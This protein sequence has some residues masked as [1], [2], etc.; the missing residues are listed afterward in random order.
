M[1][2][3]NPDIL[4]AIPFIL[5]FVAVLCWFD[6]KQKKPLYG[7][8]KNFHPFRRGLMLF[9]SLSFLSVFL[10]MGLARPTLDKLSPV[11][12]P[13]KTSS[14]LIIMDSSFSMSGKNAQGVLMIDRAKAISRDIIQSVTHGNAAVIRFSRQPLPLA[15]FVSLED[16]ENR[17]FLV[18]TIE[19][20]ELE[21][22]TQAGSSAAPLA[23]LVTE[24][25]TSQDPINPKVIVLLSDGGFDDP[26]PFFT[27]VLEE[28]RASNIRVVA[29][30]VGSITGE[31]TKDGSMVSFLDPFPLLTLA[32]QTGGLY[33]SEE[34]YPAMKQKLIEGLFQEGTW[35]DEARAAGSKVNLS[36]LF[37][38]L[39]LVPVFYLIRRH[40]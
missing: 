18:R 13:V 39:A 5:G 7:E 20:A 23:A 37:F 4:W 33:L 14:L 11:F 34:E 16:P 2:L 36:A 22:L 25:F 29:I 26:E 6:L 8:V 32:S 1:R 15:S 30:G 12:I 21:K 31:T 3:E 9:L 28:L 17:D 38:A 27:I 19:H 40:R 24:E 35:S 10:L